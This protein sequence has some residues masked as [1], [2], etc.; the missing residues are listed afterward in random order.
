MPI[1]NKNSRYSQTPLYQIRSGSGAVSNN[2]VFGVWERPIEWSTYEC[3][4]YHVVTRDQVGRLD[5]VAYKYY[6][7]STLWWVIADANQIN[8]YLE[9]ME[10]G[11]ELKI[12]RFD[13]VY[14]ALTGGTGNTPQNNI[15]AY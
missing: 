9:E 14:S 11:Q 12:P 13:D 4:T 3:D 10:A 7:E 5:L 8:N 6:G 15:P 1:I 2:F